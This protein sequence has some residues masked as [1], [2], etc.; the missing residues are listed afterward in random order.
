MADDRGFVCDPPREAAQQNWRELPMTTFAFGP[1]FFDRSPASAPSSR[2]RRQ[3]VSSDEYSPSRRSKAPISPGAL[4][5][6][7]SRTIRSLRSWL[8]HRIRR[9]DPAGG[10]GSDRATGMGS[11]RRR[12][13]RDGGRSRGVRG[14]GG[15][16]LRGAGRRRRRPV[17]SPAGGRIAVA[18]RRVSAARQQR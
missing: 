14:G 5:A 16:G 9:Q 4:H 6:S 10:A 15:E 8:L 7:A 2:C 17:S 3:A 12:S 1:R 18:P 11:H 13:R